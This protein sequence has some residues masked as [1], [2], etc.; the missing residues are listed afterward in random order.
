M[1][2]T[3]FLIVVAI[4]AAFFIIRRLSLISADRAR[5]AIRNGALVIDVREPDEY[6]SGKIPGTV[7]IP[8]GELSLRI[9]QV[10]PDKNRVVLLHCLSGVRSGIA[11]GTLKSL[12]Y[13]NVH[14]LGSYSRAKGILVGG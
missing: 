13:S 12:G 8:L 14:N 7:N 5:Q 4:L 3:S 2:W 10:C 11:V 1:N 6:G 9:G